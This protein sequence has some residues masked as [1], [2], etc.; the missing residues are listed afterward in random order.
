MDILSSLLLVGCVVFICFIS[1]ILL[2]DTAKS[3]HKNNKKKNDNK[4]SED[5]S[6]IMD[7]QDILDFTDIKVC[8]EE[9]ALIQ[10]KDK[11]IYLGVVEVEG[12]NFNL[13]SI[14]ER[15]LLEENFCE[16]LNG[17]DFPLQI[18]VQSRKTDL[19]QYIKTY[20]DRVNQIEKE[21]QALSEKEGIEQLEIDK[22][23]NQLQYA[24]MLLQYF[25]QRT[26]NANLLERRYYIVVKYIHNTSNYENNLSEYEILNTAYN[27]INNKTGVIMDSLSRNKLKSRFLDAVNLADFLYTCHNRDDA[28][29][30]RFKNAL[31]SNFDSICT[32]AKPVELKK[33]EQEIVKSEQIEQDLMDQIELLKNELGENGNEDI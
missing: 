14:D 31:Q 1:Y 28:N 22:K 5:K 33:I 24:S 10:H 30:L 19:D 20:K 13:L 18:F 12:L 15:I 2:K 26:V 9:V 29:S 32:T 25:T 7:S 16:L 27:D 23:M 8:N 6:K 4:S 11:N 3:K 21:I 17:I